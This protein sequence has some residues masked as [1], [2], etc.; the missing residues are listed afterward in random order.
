MKHI[1]TFAALLALPIV[2]A[3][4][5]TLAMKN[6]IAEDKIQVAEHAA[7]TNKKC[8]TNIA[9]SMNYPSFSGIKTDPDNANQQ[10]PW[11][12]FANV[13][14]AL[15][16][17]CGTEEGKASVKA[18]ITAVVVSHGTAETESLTAGTFKYSVPYSGHSY[19]TIIDWLKQ[20]L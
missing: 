13:T 9:F 16:N 15:D 2:A 5:Q 10:N 20:N 18:K 1:R 11:A 3:Q 4:A 6:M 17:I 12:Y 8:G 7:A 14:D 19:H